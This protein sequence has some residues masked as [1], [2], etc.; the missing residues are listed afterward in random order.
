MRLVS[1]PPES[2]KPLNV[3]ILM[4]SEQ[5]ERYFRYARIEIVDI[6]DPTGTNMVEKTF[7]GPIQ[8]QL[9]DALPP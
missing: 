9:K 3:G 6:P 1:G 7:T 5:P 4:F 8:R 2:L